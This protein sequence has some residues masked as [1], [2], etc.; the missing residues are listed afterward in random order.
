MSLNKIEYF[1][2]V[3]R[4]GSIS[5]A[6][7]AHNISASAGS[8]WLSELEEELGVSLLNR[9][10][11]KFLPSTAGL[12]LYER[13]VPLLNESAQIIESV[14][15]DA[16]DVSGI[17]KVATTPLF[18]NYILPEIISAYLS[19]FPKIKFKII[20][21]P[22]HV[23]LV[24]DFD[25]SIRASA[26]HI[27]KLD[28]ASGDTCIKL[29]SEPLKVTAAQS[30]LDRYGEPKTPNEL[31]R[32]SCLY[33]SSLVGGERW[34]FKFSGKHQVFKIHD[35]VQCDNSE[36]LRN[37]TLNGAGI[38][39]LPYSLV[40]EDIVSGKL[41]ELLKDY[42]GSTF[43][44]NLYYRKRDFMPKRILDFKDF[45]SKY[46]RKMTADSVSLLLRSC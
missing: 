46:C 19:L 23:D 36:I 2:S 14:K 10:T 37:L 9:T 13:F 11:R 25:I 38:S 22:F 17:I 45:V 18:A 3:V 42:M 32:H 26:T 33:A 41:K 27:G 24:S 30:Y 21:N 7:K 6:S 44:I 16:D 8:R 43:D 12:K 31:I 39:Y 34:E 1:C 29:L 4:L 35:S 20:I 15:D 5:M 28:R 40:V